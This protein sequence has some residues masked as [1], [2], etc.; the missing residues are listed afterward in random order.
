ML[1]PQPSFFNMNF[2]SSIRAAQS[3]IVISSKEVKAMGVIKPSAILVRV[4]AL[5]C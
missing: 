5:L 2:L 1:L 4:A 3:Y